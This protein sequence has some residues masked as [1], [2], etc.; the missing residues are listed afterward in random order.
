MKLLL[1]FTAHAVE[2]DGKF[3]NCGPAQLHY[4]H[5]CRY[6]QYIKDVVV[7]LRC[8]KANAAKPAWLRIDGEG[9]NVVPIP[10]P[11]SPLRALMM[12]PKFFRAGYRA[13][14]SCDRYLLKLPEPT[15]I[16]FGL[17]LVLLRKKYA[18][19]VMADSRAGI[20]F[21]KSKMPF[22][23]FYA[24]LFDELTKLLVRRAGC[25]AY[26]SNY[27]RS[28][29]PNK[30]REQEWVFCSAEL[31]DQII[32]KPKPVESFNVRPFKI[33]SA[34][35][36]SAEKGHI[37]LVRAFKK[38]CESAKRDVE[39]HLVGDGPERCHLE[40]E[41]KD[42]GISNFVHFHG[43]VRKGP[44]L[45]S[46]LDQAHL[47]VIPSLTEGM[48]RGMIEAMARGLPCLAS[49]VGG[50]PEYLDGNSLFPPADP[51]AI[52][53]KIL[54]ILDKPQELAGMSLQNFEASKAFWPQA[55]EAIKSK[56]WREIINNC[57]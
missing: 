24:L 9:I 23:R 54:S 16:F 29:Y 30:L 5:L 7:A 27:L 55:L 39:L 21:A 37:Y 28:R 26:V 32:G 44:Q 11:P 45:F 4:K 2:V 35:R 36:F 12:F 46:L 56:F 10:D 1:A 34:G 40:K 6:R 18:V 17:L 15:A 57:K 13:I 48:G 41:V 22:V 52:A 42:L 20:L 43:Y 31:E 33:F 25:A 47:L 8:S 53:E 19:E 49:N 51:K 50:I 38:V 14:N 3:Y